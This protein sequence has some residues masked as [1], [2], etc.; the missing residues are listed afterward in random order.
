MWSLFTYKSIKPFAKEAAF[1]FSSE[2]GKH[3]QS[4]TEEDYSGAVLGHG[5]AS[6]RWPYHEY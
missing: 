2:V 3:T 6:A 1:L 5:C 4:A